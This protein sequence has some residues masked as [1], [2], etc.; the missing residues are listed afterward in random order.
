MI[1][2]GIRRIK[3]TPSFLKAKILFAKPVLIGTSSV[4]FKLGYNLSRP[5]CAKDRGI[6]NLIGFSDVGLDSIRFIKPP[7]SIKKGFGDATRYIG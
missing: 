6:T 4:I 3:A 7:N 1:V 2:G 5:R